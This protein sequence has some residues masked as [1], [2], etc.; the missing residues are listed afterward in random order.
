VVVISVVAVT[1]MVRTWRPEVSMLVAMTLI[2]LSSL[3]MSAS[4]LIHGNVM[5]LG[6][7][8]HPI[9]LMMVVGIA[10]QGFAECFL[11]PKYLEFASKQAPPGREGLYLG[12]SN[13]NTFFAWLFAFV[14][15]GYLL[16]AICPDP[17]SLAPAVQA[18][19]GMAGRVGRDARGLRTRLLPVVRVRRRRCGLAR[20]DAD[21][22]RGDA[23]GGCSRRKRAASDPRSPRT[24]TAGGVACIDAP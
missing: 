20:A 23:V 2:P 10:I 15:A 1:Q 22:H 17:A 3:A 7:S 9:T 14:F 12:Y 5:V 24:A 16:K 18:Q 19:R 13:M 21:L 4:H 8:V 6:A 11:S